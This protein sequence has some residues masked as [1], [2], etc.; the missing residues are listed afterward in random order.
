MHVDDMT[1]AGFDGLGMA[2]GGLDVTRSLVMQSGWVQNSY[3]VL[4]KEPQ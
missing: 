1:E 4:Q 3:H 2:H